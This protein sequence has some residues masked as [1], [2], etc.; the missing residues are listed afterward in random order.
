MNA[1]CHP[2]LPVLC[3]GLCRKCYHAQW[4]D[5]REPKRPRKR[6]PIAER[7]EGKVDRSGGPDACH[8]WLGSKGQ[9]GGPTFCDERGKTV[10]GRR[11]AWLLEHGEFPP[12]NRWVTMT[13]ENVACVNV[14][15]MKLRAHHDD[16][17]RFWSFVTKGAP[18]EC[19]GWTG[20]TQKKYGWFHLW[21][22][23]A[24]RQESGTD[25][26]RTGKAM[27]AH[28]YSW[29]L[30]NGPIEG[31]VPGHPELEVC[32]LHRCDNPPCTNPE[33]LFLG[34]DA[35][36]IAD[37]IAKGRNSRGPE[38]GEKVRRAK[39]A[40]RNMQRIA[41]EVMGVAEKRSKA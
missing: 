39:E 21:L 5:G 25:I 13:C 26:V 7:F 14:K 19:W 15:H 11:F 22:P 29:V 36:N 8:L 40:R 20:A 27:S 17:A 3:K 2:E 4:R 31:N 32:V 1:A 38:H 23:N 6:K 24:K 28:T 35:D 34:T 16:E 37:C 30:H 9:G 12:D 10:S 18:G 33:H 41:E